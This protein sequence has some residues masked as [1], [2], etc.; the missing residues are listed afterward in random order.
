MCDLLLSL[1]NLSHLNILDEIDKF[2]WNQNY[3]G[4]RTSSVLDEPTGA[5]LPIED[6]EP[7]Q[8]KETHQIVFTRLN[9]ICGRNGIFR[10][11][12]SKLIQPFIVTQSYLS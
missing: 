11:A 3:I 9:M 1:I 12:G 10:I 8:V 4:Q 5:C 6:E 7:S 2:S